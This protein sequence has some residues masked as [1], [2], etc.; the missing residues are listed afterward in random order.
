MIKKTTYGYTVENDNSFLDIQF[1]DHD[2]IRFVYSDQKKLPESSPAIILK[3][4]ELE[5]SLDKNTIETDRIKIVIDEQSLKVKI[6]DLDGFLISEDCSYRIDKPSKSKDIKKED[7]TMQEQAQSVAESQIQ[8]EDMVV[9]LKKKLMWENGIYGVGEKY[10]FLNK[11]GS[12]TENWSSD[13]LAHAPL[14]HP[15]VEHYHTAIPFYIGLDLNRAYGIYHDNT[16]KTLF[17]FGKYDSDNITFKASGGKLDYYFIYGQNAK[18]IV[19]K[20]G[21]LTGTMPLPNISY[22][23]YQQSR[24]SYNDRDELMEVAKKMRASK[25]PCDVL[26]LDIDYMDNY[27]VFTVDSDAFY[28]FK[29]ML[30]MLKGLDY[31]VVVIIDPG[32]KKEKGYFVYDQGLE[33]NYFIKNESGKT[34]YVGTV[35]PGES[36]FPDFMKESAREWWGELHRDLLE[37]GVNGIWND[38]NEPADSS[39]ES[40]TLPQNCIHED[41]EQNRYLHKE[42]HNLYGLM[43]AMATYKGIEN[44]NTNERPFV[45]TRAAFAGSQRYAALWTGDNSSV[46]EHL[47][48]SIPM[49]L[50]LGLS[51][52]AFVGGDVGGF[53][54]NTTP[55]LLIRWNQLG[56]FTPFFR[57]HS[58]LGS[59]RQEPWEFGQETLSIIKNNIGQRYELMRQWYHLAYE[60]HQFG[61]PMMRPVFLEYPKDINAYDLHE[62]FLLGE[63][64]MVC[65]IVRPR[66]KK[67]MIYLPE[68]KWY[69]YWTNEVYNSGY[70]VI[71]VNIDNIPVFVKSGSAILK[72]KLLQSTNELEKEPVEIQI[73]GDEN[74]EKTFYLDDGKTNQYKFG[75]YSLIKLKYFEKNASVEKIHNGLD[76]DKIS[77]EII[78]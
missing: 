58:S 7:M 20:Y 37:A 18:E 55:E 35:W 74:F 11:L 39:T 78:V 64:I 50:N 13:V 27:K 26:Y 31:K 19:S 42:V 28:D 72:N 54:G 12:K 29:D 56:C 62:Q 73:Y 66:I 49:F 5:V 15:L 1:F 10:G 67:K 21:Q 71:D 36:V 22:L 34:N 8:S 60:A 23:G 59:T 46:W 53:I 44:I 76:I 25:V 38:M 2:I 33:N 57:N 14:H 16:Y 68:G 63:N 4:R 32:V 61:L 47:E 43:E 70:H 24:W 52:Y 9:E 41:D 3:P 6:Y 65:P 48:L 75:K 77:I 45:L 51:G 17:D 40:K 69:D 30:E